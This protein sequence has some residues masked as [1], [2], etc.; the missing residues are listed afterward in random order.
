MEDWEKS[1]DMMILK[2]SDKVDDFFFENEFGL[3]EQEKP[4]K[5][6]VKEQ[7]NVKACWKFLTE[8][9]RRLDNV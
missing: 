5:K 2:E 4:K 1:L 6:V 7:I 9:T 3:F 8:A